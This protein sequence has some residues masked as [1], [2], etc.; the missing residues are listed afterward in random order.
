MKKSKEYLESKEA[1]RAARYHK[2]VCSLPFI[3]RTLIRVLIKVTEILH[4]RLGKEYS[5]GCIFYKNDNGPMARRKRMKVV[6]DE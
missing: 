2:Q 5:V 4:F 1:F 3:S 6:T